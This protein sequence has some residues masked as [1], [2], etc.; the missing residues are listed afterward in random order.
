MINGSNSKLFVRLLVLPTYPD[1]KNILHI[2]IDRQ[3]MNS[4]QTEN[5]MRKHQNS[6]PD[7]LKLFQN[8]V[9]DEKR[10]NN[11]DELVMR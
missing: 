10:G 9:D 4:V 6:I 5:I 8:Q 7:H 1:K 2:Y 11:G 3:K